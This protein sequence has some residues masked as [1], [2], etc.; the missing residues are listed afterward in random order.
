MSE[1]FCV[2]EHVFPN[3]KKYI[4]ITSDAE[5]RWR[6]GKGYETQGKIANA[7]KHFGWEHVKHD[8]IVEGLNKEQALA[9]E[10]YLITELDT[11]ENGYNTAIGGENINT[12]Y[13]NAH[14]LKMIRDSKL[15][16]KKY[17]TPQREDDIVSFCERGKTNKQIAET[18]NSLDR[19]IEENPITRGYKTRRDE[20]RVD[21]YFYYMRELLAIKSGAK[22]EITRYEESL[23]SFLFG[24]NI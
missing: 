9:L 11:I 13:L 8:I 21:M 18:I 2:Y 19:E 20:R 23:F 7:I 24:G 6:N 22:R 5:K 1:K 14:V 10:R 3:G 12:S 15:M 4:G 16:D 17:G